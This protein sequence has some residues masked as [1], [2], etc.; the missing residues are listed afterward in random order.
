MNTGI[1]G[2]LLAWLL[3]GLLLYTLSRTQP[4]HVIIYWTAWLLVL[5]LL[6][7]HSQQISS[8]LQGGNFGNG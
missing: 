6:V 5:L 1:M 4:G 7:T 8:I 3:M 2:W